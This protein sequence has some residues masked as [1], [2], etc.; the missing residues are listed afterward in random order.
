MMKRSTLLLLA[1]LAVL[2]ACKG[3]PKDSGGT[4]TG[5]VLQGSASDAMLPVDTVRSQAP[6]APKAAEGDKPR[7]KG[8]A[9]KPDATD[10]APAEDGAAEPPAST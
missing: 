1:P 9:K 3:Q 4:A 6:L 10:S 7:D 2:A 5:E 8:A